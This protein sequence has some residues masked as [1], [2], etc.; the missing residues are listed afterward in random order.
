MQK[1]GLIKNL[2]EL[3]ESEYQNVLENEKYTPKP[4]KQYT[5]K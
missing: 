2:E 4:E 3:F 5:V 1:K